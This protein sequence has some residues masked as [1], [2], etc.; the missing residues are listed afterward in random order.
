MLFS[1]YDFVDRCPDWFILA[2]NRYI[3]IAK[4]PM[5]ATI[6]FR[7]EITAAGIEQRGDETFDASD[8]GRNMIQWFA[9]YPLYVLSH[10]NLLDDIEG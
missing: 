5:S 9:P 10:K 2:G 1:G 7:Y 3:K 6:A 8:G 4:S